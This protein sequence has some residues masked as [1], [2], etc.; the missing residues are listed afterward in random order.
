MA[1]TPPPSSDHRRDK[2]EPLSAELVPASA[3]DM[4]PFWLFSTPPQQGKE[5]DVPE[6]EERLNSRAM[7][8]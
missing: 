2:G 6:Q 3:N 4:V 8:R 5:K 7:W 1:D